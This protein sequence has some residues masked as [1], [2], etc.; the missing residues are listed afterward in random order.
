[1]RLCFKENLILSV[2][3]KE[4]ASRT[5]KFYHQHIYFCLYWEWWVCA[6]CFQ[7]RRLFLFRGTF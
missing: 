2:I 5:K 6:S 4:Q 1:M 7:V 3:E